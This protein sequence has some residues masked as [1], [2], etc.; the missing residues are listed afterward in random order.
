MVYRQVASDYAMKIVV[1][2]LGRSFFILGKD[3]QFT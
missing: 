2:A 3:S 1:I